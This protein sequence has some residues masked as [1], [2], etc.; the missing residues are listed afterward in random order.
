MKEV[1]LL[2]FIFISIL[3]KAQDTTVEKKVS[4]NGYIK[5]FETYTNA[6]FKNEHYALHLI[7][8]RINFKWKPSDHFNF[9]SEFRN[10]IFFGEQIKMTPNFAKGLRNQSEMVNLQ[11]AWIN[12]NQFIFHTNVERLYTDLIQTKWN[13]RIGRQRINWGIGTTWNPN[14]IFNT[15]NFLDIDY[16]E[17][18]GTDAVKL[19]L[20]TTDFSNLS[21]VYN[22][23][24]NK[25]I[26]TAAKYYFNKWNYDFQFIMGS[27]YGN[28][29]IGGGWAGSI[30]DAGFKGEVQYYFNNLKDSNQL[31]MVIDF[32]YMF[33][34]GWYASIGALYNSNGVHTEIENWEKINLNVS[35]RNLMPTRFST[36]TT[37]K[38]EI[39]LVSSIG[40]SLVYAPIVNLFIGM[41]NFSYNIYNA[42]DL[43]LI[44]QLYY[45]K[46]NT[47]FKKMTT[48]G[49]IRLRYSF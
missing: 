45:L 40:V 23:S 41:P 18:P 13:L 4:L 33:N 15:Y 47:T 24:A 5:A 14:D 2:L 35:A 37:F 34:K 19:E 27:Y 8:N 11:K 28:A 21:F 48:I 17:R 7:H 16:E 49:F 26:I 43:D 9:I 39:S 31:N 12:K 42:F 1:L 29:T 36:I 32:D 20:N 3:T 22:Q 25:K 44:G 38:K 46:Q 6:H 30:K 10:R